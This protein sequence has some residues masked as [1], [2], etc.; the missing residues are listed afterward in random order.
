MRLLVS[1]K[2]ADEVGGALAGGADIIDAK[3]PRHGSLGAVSRRTLASIMQFVP[4]DCP[5]S[6][7]L[8]DLS[9]ESEVER[10]IS[11]LELPDREAPTYL[12]LGFAG[13][14]SAKDIGSLLRTA[15]AAASEQRWAPEIIAVAYAD[16]SDAGSVSPAEI[17][18]AAL[19]SGCTGVLLDTYKKTG[20]HLFNWITDTDLANW[21]SELRTVGLLAAIAGGLGV[22]Q[23]ASACCPLPDVIGVRGAACEGG[24]EGVISSNRVAALRRVMDQSIGLYSGTSLG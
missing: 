23:V 10:S 24:R 20:C 19:A 18:G 12:K 1:V 15:I 22:D 3:E 6:I 13:V 7:A 8:G 2:S 5:L 16:P 17:R 4:P 14:T 21:I 11:S 9:T